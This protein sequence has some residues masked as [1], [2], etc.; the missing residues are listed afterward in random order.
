MTIKYVNKKI[1][2]QNLTKIENMNI[3]LYFSI[4]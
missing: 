3:C 2:A 4:L 1:E